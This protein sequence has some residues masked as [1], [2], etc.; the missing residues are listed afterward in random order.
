MTREGALRVFTIAGVVALVI[1]GF[2]WWKVPM[3]RD[4]LQLLLQD[5]GQ[6]LGIG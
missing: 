3:V 4:G 1:V 6:K 5:L 2:A